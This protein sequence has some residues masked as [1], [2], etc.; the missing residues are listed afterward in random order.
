M[1]DF[2]KFGIEEPKIKVK[3]RKYKDLLILFLL[4]NG[5]STNNTVDQITILATL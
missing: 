4:K 3:L 5:Y 2:I 1:S